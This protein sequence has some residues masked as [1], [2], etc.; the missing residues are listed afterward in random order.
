MALYGKVLRL[1]KE[2]VTKEADQVLYADELDAVAQ[3]LT[4]LV[5]IWAN[6]VVNLT[7]VTILAVISGWMAAL[8]ALCAWLISI[9]FWSILSR[10]QR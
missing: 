4:S 5:G 1:S 10:L 3:G 7:A 2:K 6:P 9:L 8:V